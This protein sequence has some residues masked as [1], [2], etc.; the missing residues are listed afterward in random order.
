DDCSQR[1]RHRHRIDVVKARRERRSERSIFDEL[2]SV[3]YILGGHRSAIV[4]SRSLIDVK[5]HRHG[6]G[7]PAPTISQ[8]G[9]ESSVANRV[10][11]RTNISEV[12]E[13]LIDDLLALETQGEWRKKN[14]GVRSRR[15][16]D[17]STYTFIA[18]ARN[19]NQDRQERERENEPCVLHT[20]FPIEKVATPCGVVCSLTFVLAAQSRNASSRCGSNCP[21]D[22]RIT[23]AARPCDRLF[24]Y[25]RAVVSA[26][27]TSATQRMRAA[28][29]MASPF[30]P[31]GYPVPSH[32]S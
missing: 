3:S 10:E 19:D 24:R 25:E 12:V 5:C 30:R 26:S 4:P 23:S 18:R 2:K 9:C 29:G 17:G 13:N 21:F 7:S 22:A 32:R 27:Y 8:P 6:V 1:V 11:G 20:V 14:V 16:H 31:S 28:K 15:N